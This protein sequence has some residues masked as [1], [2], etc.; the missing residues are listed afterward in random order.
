MSLLVVQQFQKIIRNIRIK[1]SIY[2]SSI[3]TK[4]KVFKEYLWKCLLTLPKDPQFLFL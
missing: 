1:K 2:Q 4:D 3:R